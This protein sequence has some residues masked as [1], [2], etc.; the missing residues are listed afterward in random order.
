MKQKSLIMI[1]PEGIPHRDS[2]IKKIEEVSNIIKA[3]PYHALPS[4]IIEEFYE[5][6][7]EKD[8]FPWLVNH[9]AGKHV[10]FY[11]LEA[12]CEGD[13]LYNL[14]DETVGPTD[15]TEARKLARKGYDSIRSW[16]LDDLAQARIKKRM[17][18]NIIHRSKNREDA[19][20]E[21]NIAFQRDIYNKI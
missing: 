18:Q 8:F 11:I 1:R 3:K 16:S 9:H 17:V 14:V 2:I 15:P 7:K 5:E 4:E 21:M 13:N 19:K 6:H 10:E 20:R 12:Q